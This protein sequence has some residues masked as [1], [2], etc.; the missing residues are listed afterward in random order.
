[1]LHGSVGVAEFSHNLLR[2]LVRHT[3]LIQRV[4]QES[5]NTLQ[6]HFIVNFYT[7]PRKFSINYS[8]GQS[9]LIFISDLMMG[10][11]GNSLP[12][13]HLIPAGL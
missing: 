8:S 7:R 6:I 3:S 13:D 11:S 2:T 4:T 10:V 12:L 5:T 1:M 9:G